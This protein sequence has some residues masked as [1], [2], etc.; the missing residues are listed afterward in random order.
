MLHYTPPRFWHARTIRRTYREAPRAAA[1]MMKLSECG[2]GYAALLT[3]GQLYQVNMGKVKLLKHQVIL[4]ISRQPA[5]SLLK[6]TIF[7]ALLPQSTRAM[8]SYPSIC[9]TFSLT[10]M[11][12]MDP[13]SMGVFLVISDKVIVTVSSSDSPAPRDQTCLVGTGLLSS[14]V[15]LI[16]DSVLTLQF[17][18]TRMYIRECLHSLQSMG[19]V[20]GT[21]IKL[22]QISGA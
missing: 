3:A 11:R 9:C 2:P 20:M 6:A 17:R 14:L 4:G 8:H 15:S 10:L 1:S 13:G 16:N 7:P 22:T 5:R 18:D 21:D 12:R 19:K